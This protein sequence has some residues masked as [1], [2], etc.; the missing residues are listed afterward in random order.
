MLLASGVS[1]T[2]KIDLKLDFNEGFV[3]AVDKLAES[4]ILKSC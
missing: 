4:D 3:V 2:E 1:E